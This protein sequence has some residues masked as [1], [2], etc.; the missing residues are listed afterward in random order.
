MR[1]WYLIRPCDRVFYIYHWLYGVVLRFLAAVLRCALCG[2][3]LSQ[4]VA[5]L[6]A[7][8]QKNNIVLLDMEAP[9]RCFSRERARIGTARSP[10]RSQFDPLA[11]R[12]KTTYF[13]FF[14]F[15]SLFRIWGLFTRHNGTIAYFLSLVCLPFGWLGLTVCL[16]VWPF[17]HVYCFSARVI[18]ACRLFPPNS[19]RE[20]GTTRH[21]L[22]ERRQ[23]WEKRRSVRQHWFTRREHSLFGCRRNM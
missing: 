18:A 14:I 6:M 10:S 1:G 9:C 4:L 3:A 8:K 17:G 2:V 19:Y 16:C 22:V 23:K 13:P 12:S 15:L 11:E 7:S 20:Y 21:S 5:A